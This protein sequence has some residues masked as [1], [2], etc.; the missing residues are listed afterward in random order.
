M[1]T[2]EG[3]LQD[4]MIFRL[5]FCGDYEAVAFVHWG[6]VSQGSTSCITSTEGLWNTTENCKRHTISL[7][8]LQ[9]LTGI[10]KLPPPQFS[11]TRLF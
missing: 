3:R 10:Y 4:T 2:A 9:L 5:F 7:S 1:L 6:Y 8:P 11:G